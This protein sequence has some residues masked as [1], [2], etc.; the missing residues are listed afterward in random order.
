MYIYSMVKD[1]PANT[2][3][4][5][6][7]LGLGR[8]PGEGNGNLLQHSC[9]GKSHGRRSLAGYSPWGHKRVRCCLVTKQEQNIYTYIYMYICIYIYI[10]TYACMHMHV[11]I[12]MHVCVCIHMHVCKCIYIY[13][14][15][16][17]S[18]CRLWFQFSAC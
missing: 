8:S 14:H 7:I 10:Y 1:L 3:D 2:E 17:P 16:F 11:C 12:H 13:S 5:G 6:S 4:M 18:T 9:L 15:R